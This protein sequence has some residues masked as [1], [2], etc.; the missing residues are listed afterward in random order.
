M[1]LLISK[2]NFLNF[3]LLYI[4]AFFC[5][6]KTL[7]IQKQLSR[8]RGRI[9]FLL[10]PEL[11]DWE[12][13]I[14]TRSEAVKVGNDLLRKLPSWQLKIKKEYINFS[15]KIKQD[16]QNEIKDLWFLRKI[17]F[18]MQS[19]GRVF[20]I[21]SFK[22]HYLS[23]ID[24][25]SELLS[26]PRIKILS[27]LNILLD[28]VNLSLSNYY[29]LFS[30]FFK[31]VSSYIANKETSLKGVNQVRYLYNCVSPR[32]L[33]IDK[34]KITFSW[35]I[36]GE[37]IK[38]D[39]IL[40]LVPKA[41]FQMKE[42]END[43]AKDKDLLA[44]SHSDMPRF[45]QRRI[46]ISCLGEIV[47]EI[48]N[49]LFSLKFSFV[50]LTKRSYYI[51]IYKWL[52]LVETIKPEVFIS[53][54]GTIGMEEPITLYL[55][56]KGIKTVMWTYSVN[57]YPFINKERKGI[58]LDNFDYSHILS[59]FLIVWNN[60]F[61]KF[62]ESHPQ[63]GVKVEV[64]GPLMSGDE[65]VMK[66]E[67]EVLFKKANLIY[68]ASFK[69]ISL[70]DMPL[71]SRKFLSRHSGEQGKWV[72]FHSENY[73]FNFINDIYRLLSHYSNL[74][75]LYKPKRSLA[76]EKFSYDDKTRN[77]FK[78]MQEDSRVAILDYNINP[79]YPIALADMCISIPFGSPSI[80]CLHY[81]KVAI[82]YD[83]FNIINFHRYNKLECLIAHNFNQMKDLVEK[84]LFSNLSFKGAFESMDVSDFTGEEFAINSSEKFRDFL[85]NI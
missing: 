58:N 11:F 57:S 75:L 35:L 37:K 50:E 9:G 71:P 34:D 28:R 81:G 61:K 12:E 16:L 20:V 36:D 8:F 13:D 14:I 65:N 26:F 64:I 18:I 47:K 60:D 40:F 46:L 21:D 49:T 32:E 38:K 15:S 66:I 43:F 33:S 42:H 53:N 77:F 72:G 82:F 45:S 10:F 30:L 62:V 52:P 73:N 31:Y 1:T 44:L 22:S 29:R 78:I 67:K 83:P 84:L 54:E 55:N 17:A 68:D 48:F 24:K 23:K 85:A 76:S 79:W 2:I 59:N 80:A 70:F 74:F 56:S 27:N 25:N 7:S 51:D 19:E 69:Y 41:D 5:R 6:I 39:K 3:P 63:N 4:M